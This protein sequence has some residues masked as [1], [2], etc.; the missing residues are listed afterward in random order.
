MVR[1]LKE[2]AYHNDYYEFFK[3][4]LPKPSKIA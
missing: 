4:V 2:Q 1:L 3:L